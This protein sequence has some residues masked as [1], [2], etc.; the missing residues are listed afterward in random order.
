MI[1]LQMHGNERAGDNFYPAFTLFTF[2]C[3]LHLLLVVL[4]TL[5]SL[6]QVATCIVRAV[7]VGWGDG[8]G[9]EPKAKPERG[10]EKPKSY[11][12]VK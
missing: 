7:R 11:I 9:R 1:S 8:E 6:I 3:F 10:K 4:V 2:K 5:F 12:R